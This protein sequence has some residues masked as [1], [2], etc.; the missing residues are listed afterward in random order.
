MHWPMDTTGAF[1]VGLPCS[2]CK[3]VFVKFD[4]GF[5]LPLVGGDESMGYP[6]SDFTFFHRACLLRTIFGSLAHVMRQCSC[7]DRSSTCGDPPVLTLREAAEAMVKYM[8]EA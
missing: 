3:E 5:V 7:Y 1:P 2:W 8:E 6:L 4:H